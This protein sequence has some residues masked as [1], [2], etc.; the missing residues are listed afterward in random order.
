MT[1]NVY[2]TRTNPS[3]DDLTALGF[4]TSAY[5][6]PLRIEEPIP[7]TKHLDYKSFF[8]PQASRCPAVVDDIKNTFV[9]KSPVD[10]TIDISPN[11]FKV[12]NQ[13][14]AFAQ[15][16]L[17]EPQGKFG[18]HQLSLCYNFFSEK[19]LLLTQLPAYY[20]TNS[21]IDNTYTI[22]ASFDIGRWYRPAAKPAFVLKDTAKQIVIKQ[23]DPLLY[24]RFNTQEKVKLIEF[25]DSEFKSMKEKSPE[26]ICTTLK[27]QSGNITPLA[28]CYEYFERYKM[29][30]RIL[31]IIKNN[32]I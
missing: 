16:F 3:F 21:F 8:G 27:R 32:I 18:V 20:D 7:L 25:D 14:L 22:S 23:G 28:K 5:M 26:W 19:S 31:K 4:P 15:A 24:I 10:I 9:I 29:R 12:E 6:S 17:G 11:S 30:N 2:W 1:I 13:D